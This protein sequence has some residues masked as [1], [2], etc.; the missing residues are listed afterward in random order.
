MQK[1]SAK[2]LIK[3]D[4]PGCKNIARN[5]YYQGEGKQALGLAVCEKCIKEL[6]YKPKSRKVEE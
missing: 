3:C 5:M 6:N 2:Y 4:I 1:I